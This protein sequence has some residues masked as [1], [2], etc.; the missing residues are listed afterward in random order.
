MAIKSQE[1]VQVLAFAR[2]RPIL[3]DANEAATEE[4]EGR[5]HGNDISDCLSTQTQR[6]NRASQKAQQNLDGRSE[7]PVTSSGS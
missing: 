1:R 3:E 6:I 2:H 7:G 5:E 4:A